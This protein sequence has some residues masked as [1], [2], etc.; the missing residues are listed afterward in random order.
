MSNKP[1]L[2]EREKKN[3]LKIN[4][5]SRDFHLHLL[6]INI[7]SQMKH[8]SENVRMWHQNGLCL[9]DGGPGSGPPLCYNMAPSGRNRIP[10]AAAPSA[11][12]RHV[13][14]RGSRRGV[15]ENPTT[16]LMEAAPRST[17]QINTRT[18]AANNRNNSRVSERK[19]FVKQTVCCLI[20]VFSHLH[21]LSQQLCVGWGWSTLGR[22][23]HFQCWGYMSESL[24]S[25]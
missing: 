21:S 18:Q 23:G 24:T 2:R 20:A 5:E 15:D 12:T 9:M 4:F 10:A 16:L 22:P 14:L 6:G 13:S 3:T 1:L 25:N 19:R 11:A 17:T 8:V 7:C